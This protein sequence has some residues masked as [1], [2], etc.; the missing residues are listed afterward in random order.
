MHWYRQDQEYE[1]YQIL[2]NCFYVVIDPD[3]MMLDIV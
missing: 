1:Y 3:Q 2:D